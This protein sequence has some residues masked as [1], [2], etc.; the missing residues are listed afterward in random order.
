[1][2]FA[3]VYLLELCDKAEGFAL[4]SK[5]FYGIFEI[6]K[7]KDFRLSFSRRH[8]EVQ[9]LTP[10]G[11]PPLEV[12]DLRSSRV[13]DDRLCVCSGVSRIGVLVVILNARAK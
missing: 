9:S 8:A 13:G 5:W 4:D 2:C 10:A 6:T 1:M 11:T 7:S 12:C 3:G